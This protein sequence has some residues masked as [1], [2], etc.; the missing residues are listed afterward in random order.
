MLS[1]YYY[2]QLNY[3]E[4]SAY[5]TLRTAIMNRSRDCEVSLSG[6]DALKVWRAVV[7]E[8]PEFIWYPGI[9]EDPRAT[10][11]STRFSFEYLKRTDDISQKGINEEIFN[12]R[13]DELVARIDSSLSRTATDYDVC[14]AIYDL[15]CTEIKYDYSVLNEYNRLRNENSADL[16]RFAQ[17]EM[18][19]FTAYGTLIN[20]LG[21]CQGISKLFNMLCDRFGIECVCIEAKMNDQN[22]SPHMLNAVEI[23]GQRAF[24]DVTN[25]LAVMHGEHPMV[26]YEYFAVSHSTI[27]KRFTVEGDFGCDSDELSYYVRNNLVFYRTNDFIKFLAAYTSPKN[28]GEIRCLVHSGAVDDCR[29]RRMADEIIELHRPHGYVHTISVHDGYVTA[30]LRRT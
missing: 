23:D 28:A 11:N 16:I 6:T 18:S 17:E 12:T 19:A 8:N 14:K 2:N 29:L 9:W 10:A 5:S 24:V 26:R 20:K 30:Y 4:K 22:Q 1:S 7:M 27:S 3:A 21:V 13:L 25:G 15:L